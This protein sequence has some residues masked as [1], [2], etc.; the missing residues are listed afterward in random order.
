MIFPSICDKKRT[1]VKIR[2]RDRASSRPRSRLTTYRLGERFRNTSIPRNV[3]DR[4]SEMLREKEK[5]TTLLSHHRQEFSLVLVPCPT[6]FVHR[7]K[8]WRNCRICLFQD[9]LKTPMDRPSYPSPRSR[10][11]H[12]QLHSTAHIRSAVRSLMTEAL[13]SLKELRTTLKDGEMSLS[14]FLSLSL[15]VRSSRVPPSSRAVI[16]RANWWH[17]KRVYVHFG[18]SRSS[19]A[20]RRWSCTTGDDV[21]P[22]QTVSYTTK[23]TETDL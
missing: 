23:D 10:C 4:L 2:I 18:M 17:G 13:V 1:V 19:S 6:E 5:V 16:Q 21:W 12:S 9:L 14:L 7:R 11:K 3:D 20:C 8:L 22:R 15:V